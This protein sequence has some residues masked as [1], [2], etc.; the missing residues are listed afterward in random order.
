MDEQIRGELVEKLNGMIKEV[1]KLVQLVNLSG[2]VADDKAVEIMM[3]HFKG[4]KMELQ[5]AVLLSIVE[6]EDEA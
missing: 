6:V 4:L 5:Q 1:D 2:V 3:D